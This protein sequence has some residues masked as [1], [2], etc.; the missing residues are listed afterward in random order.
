[1]T[2]A[3]AVPGLA[4]RDPSLQLRELS[5]GFIAPRCLYVVAEL[6][7]A[8]ALNDHPEGVDALARTVGADPD[9][10][11]R[12]L[13]L[14]AAYGVFAIEGDQVRQT[15]L[16]RMLREDHP[17]SMRPLVRLSGL[18]INWAA[19]GALLDTVRH[20][21]PDEVPSHRWV[22]YA[23]HPGEAAIFNAAMVSKARRQVAAVAAAYDFSRFPTIGDIGGGHGHLVRTIL[24]ST[25]KARGVVFDLPHVIEDAR[26]A[27]TDE[28][29]DFRAGSFFD[30]ALPTCDLYLLMEVVHDW[31]DPEAA[32]IL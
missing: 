25:P 8:D 6:G 7:V 31:P 14:L 2:R 13:R 10:L 19:Y 9:A 12:V 30:D 21:R 11:R 16:S 28:R 26:R 3:P 4:E 17:Q 1:M 27:V 20:G 23:E 29:V 5:S 22:Y 24:E 15:P 32:A 18:P